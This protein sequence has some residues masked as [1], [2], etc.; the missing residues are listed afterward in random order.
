MNHDSSVWEY[1]TYN[2]NSATRT[3]STTLRLDWI[4]IFATTS[5]GILIGCHGM[6]TLPSASPNGE[7][8]QN[9][10][11]GGTITTAI[12]GF[13]VGTGF[14]LGNY[15]H[16]NRT[17]DTYHWFGFKNTTGNFFQGTFTGNGADNRNIT[18]SDA[19][20]PSWLLMRARGAVTS[21]NYPWQRHP[22]D[23]GGDTSYTSGIP[24]EANR[25]QAINSNGFQV[26]TGMNVNT[27]TYHYVAFKHVSASVPLTALPAIPLGAAGNFVPNAPY[28]KY[29]TA[30]QATQ[31]FNN[32]IIGP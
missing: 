4:G 24:Q 8:F 17:G 15:A 29:K 30:R 1:G 26:G 7:I 5:I 20:Q 22:N 18:M 13:G 10:A 9:N 23:G 3:I 11:T 25:I 21:P 16:V 32:L 27:E 6:R 28:T 19:F 14:E 31:I 12:R 2:G